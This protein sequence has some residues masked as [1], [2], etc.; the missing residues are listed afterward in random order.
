MRSGGLF[1]F[2]PWGTRW[3]KKVPSA[4]F[5]CRSLQLLHNIIVSSIF[6]S[7]RILLLL[8]GNE[9]ALSDGVH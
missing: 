4:A 5:G 6:E 7:D 2:R 3:K 9:S 1:G 8:Y